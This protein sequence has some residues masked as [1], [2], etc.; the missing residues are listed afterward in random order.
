MRRTA[1]IAAGAAGRKKLYGLAPQQEEDPCHGKNPLLDGQ[2]PTKPPPPQGL[3]GGLDNN[4]TT[5]VVAKGAGGCHG[6]FSSRLT[7]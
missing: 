4:N 3:D 1:L 5:N 7:S 6:C 2:T